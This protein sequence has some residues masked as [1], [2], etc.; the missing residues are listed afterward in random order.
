M[1]EKEYKRAKSVFNYDCEGQLTID[2]WLSDLATEQTAENNSASESISYGVKGTIHTMKAN[3][4]DITIS[5]DDESL[6]DDRIIRTY[7]R[8]VGDTYKSST[9][10]NPNTLMGV[11]ELESYSEVE[12]VVSEMESRFDMSGFEITRVDMRFDMYEHGDFKKFEK[13]HRFMLLLLSE[14]YPE[15]VNRSHTSDLKYL[16]IIKSNR[17][18]NQRFE[19]EN[20][21]KEIESDGK[22]KA[23]NRLELRSKDLKGKDIP[24]EF[25]VTW[26]KRWNKALTKYDDVQV[27]LNDYLYRQWLSISE[28]MARGNATKYSSSKSFIEAKSD[29]I[30]TNEQLID[31][32][33]RIENL[34]RDKAIYRVKYLKK[35]TNFNLIK[36]S[37]INVA[38]TEIDRAT[39]RFYLPENE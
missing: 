14:A 27:E 32:I 37:D 31:L 13:L 20:Y 22:D 24:T 17:V 2:D 28:D 21:D 16:D 38:L 6:L 10:F 34:D 4:D 23:T 11:D 1:T 15:K 19:A 7:K 26:K 36:K 18:S 9:I 29:M 5:K 8:R 3:S 39:K 33:S 25:L 30:Y 35:K 12:C